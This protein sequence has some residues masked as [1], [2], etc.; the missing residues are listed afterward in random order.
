MKGLYAK[1]RPARSRSS[2]GQ[3]PLR[4]A[5][6]RRGGHR[7]LHHAAG[8]SVARS[9]PRWRRDLATQQPQY[10]AECGTIDRVTD[11]GAVSSSRVCTST[12]RSSPAPSVALCAEPPPAAASPRPRSA[13]PSARLAAGDGERR[14]KPERDRSPHEHPPA[15]W[16]GPVGAGLPGAAQSQRADEEGL[17]RPRG[18]PADPRHLR[19][20][21][22]RR[23]RRR[24][25]ARPDAL[26]GPLHPARPG[27]P[28]RQDRRPGARGARG[29]LLHD[30]GPHR[31]RAAVQRRAAGSADQ[32][33]FG[34]DV[35]DVTDRQ[36][37][38]YH[39]IRIE[40]VPEIWRRL[41]S[42]GLSTTEACGDVPRVMLNAGRDPREDEVI[43]A[44]DVLA[45]TVAKYVGSPEFSNLPRK[46]KTSMSGCVDHC[47][48]P[49]DRRRRLR[50]RRERGGRG[51]LRPLG[52][53]RAVD[54]PEARQRIGVFVRPDQVTDVWAGCTVFRDYGYRRQR[55]TPG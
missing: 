23:H 33:E 13:A 54:Q 14:K 22:L 35:A 52:G 47:T 44:T 45:E 30:A 39:W 20:D 38:Q 18:A 9:A 3:R 53:R 43:D 16:P 21:R 42:V 27:H 25:P 6:P 40:D 36:N 5:G 32:H 41:E 7:H 51:R 31:R 29:L 2:P 48:E 17:R 46:W 50:R 28:W 49:R 10:R 55:T 34:R 24:R 1:A 8:E 37:V 19:E 4:A 15:A 26:D 12:W 11:R